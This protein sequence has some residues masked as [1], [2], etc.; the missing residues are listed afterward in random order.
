MKQLPKQQYTVE[1]KE[2]AVRRVKDG[3]SNGVVAKELGLGDQTLRNWVAAF[4][5]GKLSSAG[6]KPITPE[7]MEISRMRAENA[8]LRMENDILKTALRESPGPY[9]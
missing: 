9:G 5:T 7:Q 3:Q 6:S 4:D 2:Q 8:R 1:F